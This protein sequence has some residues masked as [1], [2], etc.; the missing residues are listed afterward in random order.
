MAASAPTAI[1]IATGLVTSDL[2]ST[3]KSRLKASEV[4]GNADLHRMTGLAIKIAIEFAVETSGSEAV[5]NE[6]R[7][8]NK[9]ASFAPGQWKTMLQT[10]SWR[11]QLKAA[12]ISAI[13][14]FLKSFDSESTET[15]LDAAL[16]TEVLGEMRD[17]VWGRGESRWTR[18]WL[19]LT[20]GVAVSDVAL[21]DLGGPLHRNFPKAV[22]E[23]PK[24]DEKA[25]VGLQLM[26]FKTMLDRLD[27]IA[28]DNPGNSTDVIDA[29]AEMKKCGQTWF[30]RL[31]NDAKQ[32]HA[33]LS[34]QIASGFSRLQASLTEIES[35]LCEIKTNVSDVKEDTGDIRSNV[36]DI[37]ASVDALAGS[38]G[39]DSI[40]RD[41]EHTA[42]HQLPPAPTKKF[43]GR[44]SQ[45]NSL[46]ENLAAKTD[47]TV[48][49]PAGFGKTALASQSVESVVGRTEQTLAESPYPHG[50][51]FIDFYKTKADEDA[52]WGQLADDL[53]GPHFEARSNA[54]VRAI[55][56]CRGRRA[57]III[58]GGEEADGR[59]GRPKLSEILE[60][61]SPENTRLVLTRNIKQATGTSTI[62]IDEKLNRRDAGYLLDSFTDDNVEGEAREQILD[63][64]DGHPLALT[65]AGGQ[66]KFDDAEV[67]AEEWAED[68]TRNLSDPE[69]SR[70]TLRWLFERSVRGLNELT[71]DVLTV[72]GLLGRAP[73]PA[74]AMMSVFSEHDAGDVRNAIRTLISRNLLRLGDNSGDREFTHVLGYQ[75]ARDETVSRAEL[76]AGIAAWVHGQLQASLAAGQ[77]APETLADELQHAMAILRADHDQQ[78]WMPLANYLL[79]D[80]WNRLNQLGR[81]ER[82]RLVLESVRAWI[83]AIS[84]DELNSKRWQRELSVVFNNLG[85]LC[86]S[87]GDL[88]GAR[89]HFEAALEARERP[90]ASDP[91]NAGWQRDLSVSLEKLGN[92]CVSEGDLS[93]ARE[94][95]EAALEAR[96]RLAASDPGNAG[97]QRDLSVSLNKLG[98]LCVSEGDLS[99][100]REHFEAALEVARRL[101]ASDPGNAGWQRD[102][103]VSL[104]RLGNL[105]VSE[106][107]LSG[108][109][110]HFEAAL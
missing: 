15:G 105:C 95:F 55:N 83:Q 30:D 77:E 17:V 34:G 81:L 4:L 46:T 48:V 107:D 106:G 24:F 61:L 108:A 21:K 74:D 33:E 90:A 1:G 110:E 104:E 91:G 44:V 78:L 19:Y 50:V 93:G 85:D 56:A 101:A 7:R 20:R 82:V 67:L 86:V 76:R 89:E 75:F 14:G 9:L 71:R 60:V 32:R 103:S 49:G 11:S 35:T 27:T 25:F 72:A 39:G 37:K 23:L 26:F 51:V 42:P 96:E 66:L 69:E 70:K 99:G 87:E 28:N 68:P 52:V 64:L 22:R 12:D 40:A 65:W 29:I 43:Y 102:L 80:G 97:W 59:E 38:Q 62:E 3:I 2:E 84:N 54:M 73:F 13:P 92:L 36:S 88:S 31:D 16:W 58:E 45:Y 53:A 63:L 94:H 6:R 41:R 109:R 10:P 18:G 5:T 47:T 8:V 98:D 57:L 79:Y 100:A